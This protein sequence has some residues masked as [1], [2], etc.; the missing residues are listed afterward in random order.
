MKF[1]SWTYD[2]YRLNVMIQTKEGDLSNYVENGEWDLITMLVER[3]EVFY[4]CCQVKFL[5][6]FYTFS[7]FGSSKVILLYKT[8]P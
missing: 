2:G 1:A 8:K 4:S 6:F 3:N 7:H 5:V